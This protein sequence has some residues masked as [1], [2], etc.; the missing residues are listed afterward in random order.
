M[1]ALRLA[2]VT[3]ICGWLV[4][5]LGG[6]VVSGLRTGRIAHTDSSSFCKR[7]ENPLG[8]WFLVVLF[9]G[10]ALCCIYAWVQVARDVFGI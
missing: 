4:Y 5:L 1:N 6:T 9:S 7:R 3:A 2:A 10:M 8:Y